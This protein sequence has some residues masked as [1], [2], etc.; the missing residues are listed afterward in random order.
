MLNCE[1]NIACN[2]NRSLFP[3]QNKGM[4]QIRGKLRSPDR[5]EENEILLHHPSPG[6]FSLVVCDCVHATESSKLNT[7]FFV[8][9]ASAL[10]TGHPLWLFSSLLDLHPKPSAHFTKHWL[11]RALARNHHLLVSMSAAAPFD[12]AVGTSFPF[13]SGQRPI[14]SLL[15]AS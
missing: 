15:N 14:T 7:F 6:D 9:H 2:A 3:S 10:S 13:C 4:C 8:V 5:T 11:S 12:V 1:Y